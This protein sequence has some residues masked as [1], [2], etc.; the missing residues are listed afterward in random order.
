MTRREALPSFPSSSTSAKEVRRSLGIYLPQAPGHPY[1]KP[2][3]HL[4]ASKEPPFTP[5][6]GENE[7]ENE[8]A[9]PSLPFASSFSC[10]GG[11]WRSQR[12]SSPRSAG[13]S[14]PKYLHSTLQ[15]VRSPPS[16]LRGV[17]MSRRMKKPFRLRHSLAH[18]HA[19]EDLGV[20]SG[21]PAALE[22]S[23]HLNQGGAIHHRPRM[24]K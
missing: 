22:A 6:G 21:G 14:L 17:R 13:A 19:K 15:P 5:E 24:R 20:P 2:L 9:V 12:A 7:P 18:S 4:A 16:L 8:K 10:Q 3:P 23:G 11:P 1:Q